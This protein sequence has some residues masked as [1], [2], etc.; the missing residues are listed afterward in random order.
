MASD[1]NNVQKVDPN[2]QMKPGDLAFS[3]NGGAISLDQPGIESRRQ[4]ILGLAAFGATQ[5]TPKPARA[6]DGCGNC[7]KSTT[8]CVCYPIKGDET[9]MS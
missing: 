2:D 6:A 8:Q 3:Q 7:G 9:I 4:L 1:T 5:F